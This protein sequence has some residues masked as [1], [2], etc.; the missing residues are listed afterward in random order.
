MTHILAP[1]DVKLIVVSHQRKIRSWLGL[2]PFLPGAICSLMGS[3]INLSPRPSF[4]SVS[5]NII[6]ELIVAEPTIDHH[7]IVYD[8]R[9]MR[10]DWCR[11]TLASLCI[12]FIILAGILRVSLWLSWLPMRLQ[13][14]P[15]ILL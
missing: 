7:L 14:P 6:P 4:E 9:L 12:A 13:L 15:F 2:H 8:N 1:V 3:R 11:P 5:V 10:V